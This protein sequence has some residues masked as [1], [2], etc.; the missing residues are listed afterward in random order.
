MIRS[1]FPEDKEYPL[2]P[3]GEHLVK[4]NKITEMQSKTGKSMVL[5]EL[6]SVPDNVGLRLYAMNE[7]DN[8][9]MLKKTLHAITG[10]P[11]ASGDVEFSENEL[12]GNRFKVIIK[13]EEY[14]GKPQAKIKDVIVPKG[15]EAAGEIGDDLPF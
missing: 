6:L 15:T 7:G 3:E 12:E 9:W 5:F 8:R 13:H 2:L 11:Q 1:N 10:Q 4:V 14:N